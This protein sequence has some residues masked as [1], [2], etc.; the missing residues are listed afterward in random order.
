MKKLVLFLALLTASTS[1][2]QKNC[3][4]A[5]LEGEMAVIANS[6]YWKK[7]TQDLGTVLSQSFPNDPRKNALFIFADEL[8]RVGPEGLDRV[9][10]RSVNFFPA[11]Q[12]SS[13]NDKFFAYTADNIRDVNESFYQPGVLKIGFITKSGAVTLLAKTCSPK[14]AL[15]QLAAH[16]PWTLTSGLSQVVVNSKIKE[17]VKNILDNENK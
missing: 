8:E 10:S 12:W 9:L 1:F 6:S 15:A 17:T 13:N 2:A 5:E 11:S 7:I 3:T 14:M 4:E 16:A